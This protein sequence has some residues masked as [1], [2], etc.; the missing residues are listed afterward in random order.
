[1]FPGQAPADP[2][3]VSAVDQAWRRLRLIARVPDARLHDLRR[4]LGSWVTQRTGSLALVGALL[5]HSD[6]RV[7]L[8]HYSRFADEHRRAALNDHGEAVLAAAGITTV[9]T[10]L[11]SALPVRQH[12]DNHRVSSKHGVAIGNPDAELISV[13]ASL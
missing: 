4:T 1:M 11:G 3:S 9:N 5:N 2:L 8:E 12:V 7:T 6:P 13:P 10:V